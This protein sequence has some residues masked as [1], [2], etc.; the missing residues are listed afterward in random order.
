MNT[1]GSTILITGGGSGIGLALARALLARDNTV[2]VCGRNRARLEQLE[3]ELPGIQTFACDVSQA[4]DRDGLYAWVRDRF[5][6][7]NVLINNAGVSK[8]MDFAGD[9]VDTEALEHEVATNLLAPIH[10]TAA[11]LPL[12]RE[13][14][15][16]AIINITAVLAYAPIASL[17]VHSATKAALR[18]FTRSLRRQLATGPVRVIEIVPPVVDTAMQRDLDV[19]KLDPDVF[20]E[21]VLARVARGDHDIHVGQARAFRLASRIAPETLFRLLNRTVERS[22]SPGNARPKEVQYAGS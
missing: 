20:A 17:P 4:Q 11:F 13:Q 3:S 5:P 22:G 2:L 9:S 6:T 7:L 1:H 15:N 18:S 16:A 10:L 21:L 14:P 8:R 19:P 12:L